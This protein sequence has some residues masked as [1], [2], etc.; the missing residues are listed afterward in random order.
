M[1]IPNRPA[2]GLE[3]YNIPVVSPSSINDFV[4]YRTK[5]CLRKIFG[6]NFPTNCAMER[7][8]CTEKGVQ[9]VLQDLITIDESIE[10]ALKNFDK[11]CN[12]DMKDYREERATIPYLIRGAVKELK[13]KLGDLYTYQAKIEGVLREYKFYGYTDFVFVDNSTGKKI[14]VD[15]KTTKKM[16]SK[17][18]SSHARQIALYSKAL[19]CDAILLYLIP[20]RKT[21]KKTKIV[22]RRTE[23]VW[24]ELEDREKHL[25]EAYKI[26]RTMDT[27]LYNCNDKNEVADMCYPNVDDWFWDSPELIAAR[28]KVWGV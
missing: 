21:D 12:P 17:L 18:A 4:G 10:L 20:Y 26:I 2:A 16:P 28:K 15:L 9:P 8:N 19:E 13:D 3:K 5:W 22:S 27:L 24:Y 11:K 14:I 23:G 7:G 1:I 6:Y 25:E